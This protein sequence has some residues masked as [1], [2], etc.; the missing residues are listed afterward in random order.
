MRTVYLGLGT[1]LDD[2]DAW[3]DRGLRLLE[4]GLVQRRAVA[5]M[6]LSR[7]YQ[8]EAWGMIPGS[9]PFLNMVVAIETA[10]PLQDLLGLGLEVER[11]CGRVRDPRAKGY[12]NRTLD[13]DVLCT[14]EGERCEPN[15]GFNLEVP[16]PRM[17]ARRFVLQPLMDL[18]PDLVV[19]GQSIQ[20]ALRACPTTPEVIPHLIESSKI[21]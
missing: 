14:S 20:D 12:S 17:M 9:P 3:L 21:K 16:H 4:D 11:E 8:T 13:I 6:S 15:V 7:R 1:N 10:M 19:D 5:A 18:A 2:R